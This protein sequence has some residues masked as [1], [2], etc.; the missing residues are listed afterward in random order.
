MFVTIGILVCFIAH[1]IAGSISMAGSYT[2]TLKIVARVAVVLVCLHMV[3]GGKLT[4]DT[5]HAMKLSGASYFK[6]NEM[7]W[8]RRI[9]GLLIIIPLVMHLVIFRAS[10]AGAYRLE[11]F[12]TGRLISQIFMVL[13]IL[14]HVFINMRPMMISLGVKEYKAFKIDTLI[15]VSV[16]MLLFGMA[17]V[18]YYMRWISF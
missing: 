11:V 10:N 15:V 14:L 12:D 7:F 5:L 18:I 17:F 9:S 6:G 13:T 8:A 2:D 3:I 4:Y 1:A 16:L